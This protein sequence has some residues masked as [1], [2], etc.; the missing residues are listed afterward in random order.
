MI[1]CIVAI[2]QNH[3]IGLDGNMPWPRLSGDMQWFKEQTTD[4]IVVMGSKTWK[5]LGKPLPNRINVVISSRMQPGAGLVFDNPSQAIE[6]LQ[7]RF[8]KKDIFI[9][10]GQQIYDI[11]K[12]IVD[13]FYITEIAASYK[14][15]KFFNFDYVEEH[16]E[17]TDIIQEI[18]ATPTTPAYTIKEYTKIP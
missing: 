5:S 13:V 16:C 3:G 15:D 6:I 1:Y 9:I 12:D 11:L 7:E 18:P 10:G 17:E 8:S 14:C 2:E 4:Q